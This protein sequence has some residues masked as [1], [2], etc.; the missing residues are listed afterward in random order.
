MWNQN[1]T[2]VDKIF[3]YAIAI[4]VINEKNY[5]P[6][7]S[8]ECMHRNDWPKWKDALKA[9]LGYKWVFTIKINEKNEIV[10]YKARLVAQGFTQIS[11]V[12]YEETYS[13]V[14]DAITL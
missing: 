9:E 12:D 1:E 4:E 3:A 14:V 6:K 8:E 7:T 10:R 5:V 11:G 2:R 13:S